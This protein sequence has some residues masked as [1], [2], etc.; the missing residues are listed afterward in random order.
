MG[1]ETGHK[2]SPCH[3]CG[4]QA[5]PC[6][7]CAHSCDFCLAGVVFGGSAEGR[8]VI[9][10]SYLHYTGFHPHNSC[11]RS[12]LHPLLSPTWKP[13]QRQGGREVAGSSGGEHP[14]AWREAGGPP[15][16][17][18]CP[19]GSRPQPPDADTNPHLASPQLPM[20]KPH[21]VP[22]ETPL[23]ARHSV[24]P[25]STAAVSSQGCPG[26]TTLRAQCCQRGLSGAGHGR[27]PPTTVLQTH[28]TVNPGFSQLLSLLL[29]PPLKCSHEHLP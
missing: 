26:Q 25:S 7:L 24:W 19:E 27:P 3:A 16:A 5:G 10:T 20:A 18:F 15:A 21:T 17:P 12:L 6:T 13:S 2:A 28:R 29:R 8:R 11:E 22:K 1:T 23:L 9:Q 4:L 14:P